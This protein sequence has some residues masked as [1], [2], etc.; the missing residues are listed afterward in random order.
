MLF[1]V[2]SDETRCEFRDENWKILQR[3]GVVLFISMGSTLNGKLDCMASWKRT[4]RVALNS[5]DVAIDNVFQHLLATT[6]V[7]CRFAFVQ[8]VRL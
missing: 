5:I 6:D 8:H 4:P 7:W 3:R 1:P 2:N